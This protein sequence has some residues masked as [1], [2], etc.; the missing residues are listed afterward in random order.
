[1]DNPRTWEDVKAERRVRDLNNSTRSAAA[2]RIMTEDVAAH[3]SHRS[4]RRVWLLRLAV[5]LVMLLQV[6][7]AVGW[8]Y[9][10]L[11]GPADP[12]NI[13]QHSATG[14]LIFTAL[15]VAPAPLLLCSAAVLAVTAGRRRE[16]LGIGLA[17]AV[18][19][20]VLISGVVS[21]GLLLTLGAVAVLGLLAFAARDKITAASKAG[22]QDDRQD[23]DT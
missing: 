7:Y 22:D 6:V 15:V 19:A 17:V 8:A 14:T 11:A 13:D 3:R 2:D 5:P 16:W 4:R 18:E 9:L 10:S 1:M 20:I 12:E 21:G 23:N